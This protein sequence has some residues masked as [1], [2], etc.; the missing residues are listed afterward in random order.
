MGQSKEMAGQERER[1]MSEE[2][3]E[4]E[5]VRYRR[6]EEERREKEYLEKKKI[7]KYCNLHLYADIEPF[8]VVKIISE[9]CVEVRPMSA[10]QTAFPEQFQRGGFVGHYLDQHKQDYEYESIEGAKVSRVRWSEAKQRWQI[11][12]MRF[13]M[14]DTP[15]KFYDYNF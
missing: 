12:G 13:I 10:K 8:E 6:E 7:R 1:Q 4:E 11:G 15:R 2:T 9:K 5:M 3:R 14:S